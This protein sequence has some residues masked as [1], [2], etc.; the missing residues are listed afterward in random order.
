MA[1]APERARADHPLVQPSKR[2]VRSWALEAASSA[3]SKQDSLEEIR[4]RQIRC[5]FILIERE[6]VGDVVRF[7]SRMV[8][9]SG[10]GGLSAHV[11]NC[12]G[13]RINV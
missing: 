7:S 4:E 13:G 6:F 5:L 2:A 11:C 8:R 3:K 9:G 12:H 10:T 1:P